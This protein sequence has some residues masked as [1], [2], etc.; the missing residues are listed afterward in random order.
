MGLK[1]IAIFVGHK[2]LRSS[3]MSAYYGLAIASRPLLVF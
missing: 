1:P 3:A 2:P